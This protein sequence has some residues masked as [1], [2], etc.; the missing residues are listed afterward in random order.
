MRVF[1]SNFTR[2]QS[3]SAI[4]YDDERW[5]SRPINK[6]GNGKWIQSPLHLSDFHI[7]KWQNKMCVVS[8]VTKTHH[9]IL[10]HYIVNTH[11]RIIKYVCLFFRTII[12]SIGPV[13]VLIIV[14]FANKKCGLWRR[15]KEKSNCF[16][17][18]STG[19]YNIIQIQIVF[20]W[21]CLTIYQL[22]R[23]GQFY[24]WRKIYHI[25]LYTS[26]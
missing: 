19:S 25:M 11:F 4:F 8:E 3:V 22:Y 23:A 15:L 7:F 26:P 14:F 10:Q 13:I 24:W 5:I 17:R 9:L 18:R 1:N 21:W 20:V 2:P 16:R 6:I 12:S